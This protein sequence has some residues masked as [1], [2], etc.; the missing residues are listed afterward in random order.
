MIELIEDKEKYFI[1]PFI[2]GM[3]CNVYCERNI[4]GK[5]LIK[6]NNKNNNRIKLPSNIKKQIKQ[7][8]E[9]SSY[10]GYK[11]VLKCFLINNKENKTSLI[12]Y[13]L[14]LL[15][16]YTGKIQSKKY[17]IRYENLILRFLTTKTPDVN[18]IF[19]YK[20]NDFNLNIVIDKFIL[21]NKIQ[22]LIFRKNLPYK[23][24]DNDI[25]IENVVTQHDGKIID[26][27]L[28][29]IISRTFNQES[30]E[31]ETE[32]EI[33][34]INSF[35]IFNSDLGKTEIVSIKNLNDS[36]RI[37][38]YDNINNLLNTDCTYGS[39]SILNNCGN[40]FLNF[41]K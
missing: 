13:D 10:N 29:T 34:C 23:F 20:L 25:I 8:Y 40:V 7:S 14:L 15:D 17:N 4:N 36:D 5:T 31:V 32:T 22:K 41:K 26:Y 28:G 27:E 11:I 33:P 18:V 19:S 21:T 39:Y 35:T 6:A 12:V 24:E 38:Y 3:K 16:E 37:S 1:Q 30:G 2:S 9:S